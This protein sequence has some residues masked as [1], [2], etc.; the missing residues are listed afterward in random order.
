MIEI[1]KTML[2]RLQK[3]M[4][5]IR[6]LAKFFFDLDS[7]SWYKVKSVLDRNEIEVV[8]FDYMRNEEFSEQNNYNKNKAI[9]LVNE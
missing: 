7:S 8:S 3:M 9:L 1:K 5:L 4:L 2:L 6:L